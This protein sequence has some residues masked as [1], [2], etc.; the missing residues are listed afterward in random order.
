M[1]EAFSKLQNQINELWEKLDKSQKNRVLITSGILLVVLTVSIVV[2]TRTNYVPLMVVNDS[3]D[4]QEIETVLEE[5]NIKY[6]HGDRGSLLVDSRDKNEAEF[7]IASAGLTSTGMT[8]EDA[9]NLLNI[10]STESDKKQLWQNFKT[11]NLIAKLRMF[12]NVSDADVDLALPEDSMFFSGSESNEAT[13]FV[14]VTPRGNISPEQVKGIVQVV[15]SSIEG[16]DPLNVTV[17]DNNFNILNSD[18]EPGMNVPSS[19]YE[20]TAQVKEDMERNIRALYAGRSNNYD[21]I[22]V[23]ANPV[24]DFDQVS[25]KRNEIEKPTDLDEAIVSSQTTRENLENYAGEDVP[26][27]MDANP[28]VGEVPEYPMDGGENSSYEKR[29]E[30]INRVFTETLTEEERAIGTINPEKSSMTVALWYG[31]RV[32]DDSNI[33]PEF[34]EQFTQDVSNATGIPATRISVSK[35]PLAPEEEVVEPLGDRIKNF[36]DTYGFFILMILLIIALMIALMPKKKEE[37]EMEPVPELAA[38][39]PRFITPE[40]E[41]VP[42]IDL[43]ERSEVKKQIEKIVKEK[44]DTVANLLRNWL[45]DDFD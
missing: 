17:V 11:N 20:L 27:G 37:E 9:W 38:E 45:S 34:L 31:Q 1:S 18:M 10:S 25:T 8:F 41:D 42:E 14:R 39:G 35:Y 32:P 3:R 26:P 19:Q 23:V 43:G 40:E 29:T 36:I 24:L 28:G 21:F 16:L 33:T 30:I 2:L 5:R 6:K 12:D 22:S 13:A 7:A 4:A 44:P 15:A